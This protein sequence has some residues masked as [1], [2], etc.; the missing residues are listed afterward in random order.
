MGVLNTPVNRCR[1]CDERPFVTIESNNSIFV[2]CLNKECRINNIEFDI[3]SWNSG[4]VGPERR[5]MWK[6]LLRLLIKL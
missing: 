2:K 6:R 4:N 1:L 3:N 5:S